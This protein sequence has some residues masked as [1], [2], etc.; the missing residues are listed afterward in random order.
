MVD[1]SKELNSYESHVEKFNSYVRELRGRSDITKLNW[2]ADVRS[3]PI[4][5]INKAE[6]FYIDNMSE[7]LHPSY[8]SYVEQF[9]VIS[10]TNEAPIFSHRYVFPIKD[11]NGNVIN[12]VG[13]S[14]D[15][16]ERYIYGTGKYYRR[17]DTLYG[18]ENIEFA[19]KE[20]WAVLTEG[21]TD[22]LRMR[23]LGIKNSFA[24]CGT[25]SSDVI[26]NQLNRC[27]YGIIKIPDRDSAGK[28]AEK[29]WITNRSI[30]IHVYIA[31][32][33]VDEM[34]VEEKNRDIF[35]EYIEKC[36]HELKKQEHRGARCENIEVA[37]L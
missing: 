26:L 5:A 4:E 1:I 33:D 36:E 15:A 37:I 35:M 16:D 12:L 8:L 13:Y 18:L 25:H 29:Q 24:M 7:L 32:K 11:R 31:Y 22:A 28:L 10:A 20:G 19:Y 30:T 34:L 17:R 14:R 9:G 2:L 27:R 23:S 3:M 21:I 6:I